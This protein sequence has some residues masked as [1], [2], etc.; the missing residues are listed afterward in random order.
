MDLELAGKTAI[1]TGA[2]QG[3][4]REVARRLHAEGV[5]LILVS[6]H[7]ESLER[8]ARA[9]SAESAGE[10]RAPVHPIV[11]DLTLRAEVE[12]IA[13]QAI[14]RFGHVD[15]LVNNAA[16]AKTGNF[17]R[18]TENELQEVWQVKAF[19]YVRMVRAIAPHMMER[20]SGCIINI[21][22]GT[23]RTPTEDFIVGSMVNAALVN[24]TRGISRELARH[25][26]RINSVSPGWTLTERVQRS[27]ELQ[28]AAQQV[29]VDEIL[30]REARGIPLRRL[31]TMDELAT[32]V[33]L[34]ASEKLPALTGEDILVD[35]GATPSI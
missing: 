22:G 4:G 17:F 3:I 2:S 19:G 11:A 20:N 10:T 13:L 34:L 26:V 15:I 21:V 30:R 24:F 9:I 16:R 1:V 12:R 32:I 33:L 25:N 14:E 28:A 6:L 23:A 8:A 27:A 18:M 5:S 7:S 31:V 29:S 35:G